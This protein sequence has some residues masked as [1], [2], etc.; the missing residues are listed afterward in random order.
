M[1]RIN[2]W[3]MGGIG[4]ILFQ[5]FVKKILI[6][7]G[8]SVDLIGTLLKKNIYTSSLGWT[9]HEPI[10]KKIILDNINYQKIA[11]ALLLK[12]FL[13]IKVNNKK[14]ML[15]EKMSNL[16]ELIEVSDLFGYFQDKILFEHYKH[17]FKE[18]ILDLKKVIHGGLIYQNVIH[19]RLGDLY[20]NNIWNNLAISYYQSIVNL[21]KNDGAIYHIISDDI[22]VAKNIF[23]E[24]DNV[25]LIRNTTAF[26]DFLIICNSKNLYAS[27]STFSWWG[28]HL[29][30]NLDNLWL[31]KELNEKLGIH[32]DGI[33]V[34]AL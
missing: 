2:L 29:S 7:K 1:K 25:V 11:P 4:N 32:I 33:K 27:N 12:L 17:L 5:L 22:I 9:I 8:M 19:V 18:Y 15:Y 13:V 26:D 20:K 23:K 21:I 14:Y 28:I 3:L 34:T 10:Y 24:C 30:N 16:D 31:P 6:S